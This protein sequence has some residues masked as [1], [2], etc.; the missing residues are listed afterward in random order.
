VSAPAHCLPAPGAPGSAAPPAAAD[1]RCSG[2]GLCQR[3]RRFPC[4]PSCCVGGRG[5]APACATAGSCRGGAAVAGGSLHW[6]AVKLLWPLLQPFAPSALACGYAPARRWGAHC[7]VAPCTPALRSLRRQLAVRSRASLGQS[8]TFL[9]HP[10]TPLQGDFASATAWRW[11]APSSRCSLL[12]RLPLAA[13]GTAL[14]HPRSPP[15]GG[16]W[17]QRA[18]PMVGSLPW[19]S[20]CGAPAGGCGPAG[21]R[22]ALGAPRSSG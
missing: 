11:Y 20:H 6:E 4:P 8:S 15:P 10:P 17:E 12:R 1:L 21:L 22:G 9:S 3:Q 19:E 5:T 13:G 2:R 18:F 16:S 14:V 7:A